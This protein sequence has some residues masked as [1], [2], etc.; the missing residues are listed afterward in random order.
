MSAQDQDPHPSSGMFG[1]S[2]SRD[3]R[4]PLK[5]TIRVPLKKFYKGP[6]KV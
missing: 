4:V 3:C 6:F 1:P 5:D 2:G